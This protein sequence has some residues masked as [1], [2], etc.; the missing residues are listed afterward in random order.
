[1]DSTTARQVQ[2]TFETLLL[3]TILEP[4]AGKDDMLGSYGVQ[5]FAQ[6]IAERL[7]Q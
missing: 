4:L 7:P 5:T 3:E 1:V 2:T 6:L